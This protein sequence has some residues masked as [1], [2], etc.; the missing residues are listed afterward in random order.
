MTSRCLSLE[1]AQTDCVKSVMTLHNFS[2]GCVK[3]IQMMIRYLLN[4]YGQC[5]VAV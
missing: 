3:R 1:A 5:C 2:E 4:K